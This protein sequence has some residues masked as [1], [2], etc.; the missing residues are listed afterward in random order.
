MS[1]RD[2]QAHLREQPAAR[3][4]GDP[5]IQASTRPRCKDRGEKAR[6]PREPETHAPSSN[7]AAFPPRTSRSSRDARRGGSMTD[8]TAC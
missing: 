1:T 7:R 5:P 3:G 2:I 8:G 4:R 6:R